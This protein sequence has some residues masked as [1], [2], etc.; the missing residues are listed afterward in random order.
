M[1]SDYV[2]TEAQCRGR[3]LAPDAVGLAAYTM[4][5]HNTQ[6]YVKDGY[7]SNEGDVQ[8]GG[9]PPYPIAYQSIVP[10]A[11][12]CS[13]LFVPV[14]LS[15]SH[16]AYGSI[17]MEPVFM[18]LGQS[19]AT[20]AVQAIDQGVSV[21][22]IDVKKLQAKLLEDKQILEWTGPRQRASKTVKQLSGIVQDDVS[23]EMVGVWTRSLVI[24]GFVG[25]H[26]LHDEN[27]DQGKKQIRFKLPLPAPGK[28]EVRISYIALKNRATNVPVTIHAAGGEKTVRVN[29]QKPPAINEL[30]EPLGV[31]EFSG[32]EALIV[33]GN[34]GANGYV[35]AD[36]VQLMPAP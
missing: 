23:A 3:E 22:K 21:Q 19:S 29:Q 8:V 34:E 25:D 13:N 26:Y 35:I 27:T 7:A 33:I 4:D 5:S 10:K 36:A 17:R 2:M 24:G 30:F 11:K 16:I 12:E 31:Y 1:I 32:K 15:A 20:A 6:R 18:V 9:F 14:C 28:Y